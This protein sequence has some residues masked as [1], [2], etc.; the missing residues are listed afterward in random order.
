LICYHKVQT[1]PYKWRFLKAFMSVWMK[2]NKVQEL[3]IRL[4]VELTRTE[5]LERALTHRS[6]ANET[7]EVDGVTHNERLEFLGDAVLGLLVSEMLIKAFPDEQEGALSHMRAALVNTE[8]LA[9]QA[10]NLGLGDCLLLGKGEER[11]GG[12]SKTSLLADA[13]EA[14]LAAVYL[15]GGL[16]AARCMMDLTLAGRVI[17]MGTEKPGLDPK[18]RLQEF[19]QA[20]KFPPPTYMLVQA[21][22]PDH[23]REF[24]SRW[25]MPARGSVWVRE[26]AKNWL[27]RALRRPP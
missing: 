8:E 21:S 27:S 9:F 4:G 11:S 2:K 25:C 22:G 17:A 7:P 16:D 12:R 14:V 23:M 20:L 6:Y 24:W 13:F 10:G 3:A 18:S 1:G 26:K 15:D 5:L 19:Y